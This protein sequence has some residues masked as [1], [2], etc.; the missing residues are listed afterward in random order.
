MAKY[1]VEYKS[2]KPM[3]SVKLTGGAL[4]TA[5]KNNIDF[6]K[7]FDTDGILYCAYNDIHDEPFSVYPKVERPV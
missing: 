5:F 3:A 6:L 7:K 1:A 2:R 4:M